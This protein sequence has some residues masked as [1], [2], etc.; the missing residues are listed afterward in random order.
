MAPLGT[1]LE[2]KSI[3]QTII[4]SA[5]DPDKVLE[6]NYASEALNNSFFLENLV[7]IPHAFSYI[8]WLIANIP[9]SPPE[10]PTSGRLL[11]RGGASYELVE[12]DLASPPHLL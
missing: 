7:R 10:T 8:R 5:R 9:L 3:V 12:Q 11:T 1:S 4:D 6:F 2:N